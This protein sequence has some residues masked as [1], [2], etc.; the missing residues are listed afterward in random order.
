LLQQL[1]DDRL[2]AFQAERV[3]G[4]EEVNA[5]LLGGFAAFGLTD[6]DRLIVDM[7]KRRIASFV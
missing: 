5:Q 4:V 3:D 6:D 2:L 7:V 1:E